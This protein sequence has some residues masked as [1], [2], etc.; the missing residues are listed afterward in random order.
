VPDAAGGGPPSDPLARTLGW[1]LVVCVPLAA[2]VIVSAM[3]PS[4]Q[5][6]GWPWVSLLL[7]APVAIWGAWPLHRAA[8]LGL[9]Y[10][11]ATMT[12]WSAWE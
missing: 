12:R 8:W 1:R 5:F 7:A 11:A 2:A 4:A 3:V 10:A 9:G 6:T